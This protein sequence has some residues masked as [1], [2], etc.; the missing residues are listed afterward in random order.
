MSASPFRFL[1][2]SVAT[3]DHYLAAKSASWTQSSARRSVGDVERDAFANC[4]EVDTFGFTGNDG[5]VYEVKISP[6]RTFADLDALAEQG[7]YDQ[8]LN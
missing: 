3:G 7:K 8:L 1:G 6:G 5:Q 4:A 2:L